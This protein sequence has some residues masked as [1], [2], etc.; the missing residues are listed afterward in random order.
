[1]VGLD[2]A[3]IRM[4]K[5]LFRRLAAAGTT[6]FMSTHTLE[7]AEDVCDRIGIIH[8]GSL[9]AMGTMAD[10]KHMASRKD[11]NLEELFLKLTEEESFTS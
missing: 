8:L 5:G 11:A 3:G 4:I 10:L 9:I 7:V 6:I 1:M 2:P